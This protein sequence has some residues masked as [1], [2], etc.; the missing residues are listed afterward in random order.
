MSTESLSVRLA[1]FLQKFTG[2]GPDRTLEEIEDLVT[3]I[4]HE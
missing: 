2:I 4:A 3:E 1:A